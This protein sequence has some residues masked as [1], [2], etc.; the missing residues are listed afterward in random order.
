MMGHVHTHAHI[1]ISAGHS[2][3]AY[4]IRYNPCINAMPFGINQYNVSV[5]IP[6]SKDALSVFG[7]LAPSHWYTNERHRTGNIAS[8]PL[9]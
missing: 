1:C 9:L 7:P 2:S 8:P 5:H 4:G 6:N 3:H